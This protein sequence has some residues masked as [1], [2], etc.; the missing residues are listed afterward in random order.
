[1]QMCGRIKCAGFQ[2]A[3]IDVWRVAYHVKISRHVF[4]PPL[5]QSPSSNIP[6]TRRGRFSRTVFF[7]QGLKIAKLISGYIVLTKNWKRFNCY[8]FHV[9]LYVMKGKGNKGP[10]RY[11]TMTAEKN[12]KSSRSDA[13]CP[14]ISGLRSPNTRGSR[15]NPQS[16][17]VYFSV[18]WIKF[19]RKIGWL[20]KVGARFF[21]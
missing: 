6:T 9:K 20:R 13:L 2:M 7:G 12:P 18:Y 5:F 8:V 17:V 14:W 11:I 15:L 3:S 4:Q 21:H 19:I 16:R 1:M 10:E